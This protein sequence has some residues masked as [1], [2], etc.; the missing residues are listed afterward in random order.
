MRRQGSYYY[1]LIQFCPDLSRLEG[2]NIGLALY[3][4]GEKRVAVQI[5]RDNRRI[6]KFFGNQ[7]WRLI[8]RGKASIAHQLTSQQFLNVEEFEAYISKRANFIQLSAPRAVQ[9]TDIQGSVSQL[10]ERL[11]GRDQVE[12]KGRINGYLTKKLVEA[13]VLDM[14]ETSIN[15]EISEVNKSIRVPYGYQNGRFNLI[16]PVQFGADPEVIF[17]KTGKSAIEGQLLYTKLDPAFGE[18]RLVVVAGFDSRVERA[19]QE[20]IKKTLQEHN[21][22]IYSFENLNQLVDD[23][24]LS[25]VAHPRQGAQKAAGDGSE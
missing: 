15:V 16:S 8:N 3:S 10:Y 14:V 17:E 5:T 4:P 9:T 21:V 7:D 25:A 6:R 22:A 23:I 11:V 19:T 2:V 1:S 12:R 18:M 20:F 24:R 13:G